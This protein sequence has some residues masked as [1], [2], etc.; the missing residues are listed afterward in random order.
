MT[1]FFF[2]FLVAK[3]IVSEI[4]S[5]PDLPLFPL[6]NIATELTAAPIFLYFV[7]EMLPKH[8]LMSGV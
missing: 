2:F 1:V 6:R 4:T 8:G 5:V 7:S 3:K